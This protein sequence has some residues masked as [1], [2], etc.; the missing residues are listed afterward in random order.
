[1]TTAYAQVQKQHTQLTPQEQQLSHCDAATLN[2]LPLFK[3]GSFP[4]C[5]GSPLMPP[6]S[7][8]SQAQIQRDLAAHPPGQLLNTIKAQVQ[9]RHLAE[10][11]KSLDQLLQQMTDQGLM[12]CPIIKNQTAPCVLTPPNTTS[13]HPPIL[14]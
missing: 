6:G 10:P 4:V 9:A 14:G 12:N 2:S 8:I 1:M 5:P 7:G 13:I 11:G 3:P